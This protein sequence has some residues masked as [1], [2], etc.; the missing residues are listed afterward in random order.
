MYM[1]YSISNLNHFKTR[2]TSH[3]SNSW[4]L[5]ET[6]L[7]FYILFVSRMKCV[8]SISK[9]M[10]IMVK[11]KNSSN[12]LCML[13]HL[14]ELNWLTREKNVMFNYH[15]IF[16]KAKLPLNGR[17]THTHTQ[18]EDPINSIEIQLKKCCARQIAPLFKINSN[19]NRIVKLRHQFQ[20]RRQRF[21][22]S[23]IAVLFSYMSWCW[24]WYCWCCGS[25]CCLLPQHETNHNSAHNNIA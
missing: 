14:Y 17:H 8:D 22:R 24:F 1:L 3:Y 23:L 25:F 13:K 5:N 4:E 16:V 21:N 10:G 18:N 2:W 19:W 20:W 7:R 12:K 9:Q 11:P 6:K 15:G